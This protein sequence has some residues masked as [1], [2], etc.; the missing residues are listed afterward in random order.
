MLFNREP[1]VNLL[2][3]TIKS[4]PIATATWVDWVDIT[5]LSLLVYQLLLA[6]RGTRGQQ[7]GGG[8]ILVGGVYAVSKLAGLST[9]AWV[10]DGLLVYVALAVV[11]LFQED[12]RRGLA[13]AGGSVFRSSGPPSEVN[14]REQV[15]QAVFSLAHRKIGALIAFERNA[16]LVPFTEGAQPLNADVSS[17]LLQ[18]VFHPSSQLHDGAVV[19]RASKMLAAG[20]FVPISMSKEIA[21]SYERGIARRWDSPRRRMRCALSCPRSGAQWRSRK[22]DD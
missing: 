2:I 15:I 8:L 10:F 4:T 16:S 13:R 9:L 11:I 21:K 17:E 20:V 18:A 6:L 12:I 14:I 5:V 19:I 7:V 22:G 1:Y 3:D